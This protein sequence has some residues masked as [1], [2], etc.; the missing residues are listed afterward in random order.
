M[1]CDVNSDRLI[2]QHA[3]PGKV[4]S[5]D[6]R[7]PRLTGHG[8]PRSKGYITISYLALIANSK[9]VLNHGR[10]RGLSS[11][12]LRFPISDTASCPPNATIPR[13]WV[14][15]CPIYGP[16][17]PSSI[18]FEEQTYP[19]RPEFLDSQEMG[20]LENKFGKENIPSWAQHQW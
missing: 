4:S 11:S 9:S 1:S 17:L 14:G 10:D 19:W 2:T 5:N 16:S 7:I 13:R 8:V 6:V 20:Q 3:Q 12:S 15:Y 18:H